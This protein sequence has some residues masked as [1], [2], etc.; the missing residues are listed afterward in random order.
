MFITEASILRDLDKQTQ[1]ALNLIKEKRL[2]KQ[3]NVSI[4]SL[5]DEVLNHTNYIDKATHTNYTKTQKKEYI[6]TKIEEDF[7]LF[8]K[9]ILPPQM[10][11]YPFCECHHEIIRAYQKLGKEILRELI[12][13]PRGHGKSTL[14][15]ALLL[16][17]ICC[18]KKKYIVILSDTEDQAINRLSTVTSQIEKNQKISLLYNIEP[19]RDPFNHIEKWNKTNIKANNGVTVIAR[20][21]K[22]KLRGAKEEFERP[23]LIL[24]DDLENLDAVKN[25]MNRNNLKSWWDRD[26]EYLGDDKITD[27]IIVGTFIHFDGLLYNLYKS[28]DYKTHLYKAIKD[29]GTPLWDKWTINELLAKRT[30]NP[31]AFECEFQ[32]NP[33]VAGINP[34]NHE[35]FFYFNLNSMLPSITHTIGFGDFAMGKKDSSCFTSIITL[36][37]DIANKIYVLD[38]QLIRIPPDKISPLILSLAIKWNWAQF[39]AE[40]NNFQALVKPIIQKYCNEHGYNLSIKEVNQSTEK[41]LRITVLAELFHDGNILFRDDWKEAYEELINQLD[42]FPNGAYVDGPDSLEGG[43]QLIKKPVYSGKMYV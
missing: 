7:Y 25:D 24:A 16:W 40:S 28:G 19:S 18:Q 36:G 21:S 43:Y 15:E 3:S 38:C 26:I 27:F 22:Q 20:G 12:A 13:A 14:I 1:L 6:K 41:I 42:F 10:F 39:G 4:D 34:F 29:D 11:K 32:N 5:Y 9:I 2:K 37:K 35:K 31:I 23:D 30:K 8:I 33:V 17:V